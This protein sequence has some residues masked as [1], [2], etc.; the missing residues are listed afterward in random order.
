VPS[1]RSRVAALALTMAMVAAACG[2]DDDGGDSATGTTAGGTDVTTGGTSST[3]TSSGS[4][5]AGPATPPA[6]MEAWEKLWE[7][8]R[9]AVVKNITDNKW[10]VSADGK[11]L[12]GPDGFTVDLSRC[13]GGSWN[14]TEGLTDTEIKFGHTISLSGTTAD[15]GNAAKTTKLMFD[16]YGEKGLFTDVNGKNRK[17]NYIVKDDGYDPARTIPLVDELIDSEK[18]FAVLSLGTPPI[19]RTYDKLNARCIPNVFMQS[20]HPAF[21][22][23]ENFP[24]TVGAPQT[25]YSTEAVLWGAFI[26]Q[27]IDEFPKD[28][29]VKVAALIMNNDFGKI[30]DASFRAY[31]KDSPN[32]DRIEYVTQTVEPQAPSI[33]DPM[34]TLAAGGPDFFIAMLAAQMCTQAVVAAAENGMKESVKYKMQPATCTGAAFVNKEKVGGDGMAADGWWLMNPAFKDFND[35]AQ[36]GDPFVAWARDLMQKNGIDPKMSSSFGTGILF[37]WPLVQ[38]WAIAGQLPGGLTRANAILAAR[39]LDMT[40]AGHLPGVR[41]HLS[42]N[43]DAYAAEAGV[44][45]QWDAAGQI[46]VVKGSVIDLDGKS[47]PCAW[48]K[49]A[50]VCR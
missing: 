5:A 32:K 47:K 10:G 14:N 25:S 4:G 42:G 40:H 50:A 20:A 41:L 28:R 23:P 24:W 6:S 34:T 12:T 38:T 17:V 30:Y 18:V 21:G 1:R 3:T 36:F 44:F 46:W 29:K 7:E 15:Y 37:T 45:Q 11:T 2:G 33:N 27:R 49:A 16:Y 22:D 31:L 13:S 43:R 8:Q 48:D 19:L 35:P 26:D 39:A 9:A